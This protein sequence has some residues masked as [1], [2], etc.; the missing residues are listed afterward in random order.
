MAETQAVQARRLV[1]YTG[2]NSAEICDFL[3]GWWGTVTVFSEGGGVLQLQM[4]PAEVRE[5]Q[6]G[7]YVLINPNNAGFERVVP[8]AEFAAQW[9]T[10]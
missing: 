3:T 6:V 10:V 9:A 5:V 4:G 8:A 7:E 2:S 1:E